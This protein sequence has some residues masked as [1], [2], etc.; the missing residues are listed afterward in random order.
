MV[1]GGGVPGRHLLLRTDTAGAP[2]DSAFRSAGRRAD[3]AEF[4]ENG[5]LGLDGKGQVLYAHPVPGLWSVWSES[6]WTPARGLD[7]FPDVR[8]EIRKVDGYDVHVVPLVI[9]SIA[10]IGDNLIVLLITTVDLEPH[11]EGDGIYF[12]FLCFFAESGEY[13]GFL[14]LPSGHYGPLIARPG[15]GDLH[16]AVE[17][18]FPQVIRYQ[19]IEGR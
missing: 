4:G 7:L 16:I 19:V 17:E 13:L 15:T 14:R 3:F 5:A 1:R 11:R 2:H 6:A 9:R 12:S 10:A 8:G 18:P